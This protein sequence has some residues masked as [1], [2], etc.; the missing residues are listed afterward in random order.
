MCAPNSRFDA[1]WFF[2]RMAKCG[3]LAHEFSRH[4]WEVT[5]DSF[6]IHARA[7]TGAAEAAAYL[8]K[9]ISKGFQRE[10]REDLTGMA[11]RWSSS[12]G[13]PGN[14]DL[15]LR[16][17]DE[18]GWDE[19]IFAPGKVGAHMLG[20]PDDLME[21]VGEDIVMNVAVKGKDNKNIAQLRRFLNDTNVR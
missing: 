18:G 17:T 2:A 6:I 7:V 21:R 16:Q 13:W 1:K 3:C 19:R 4:W 14:I 9:Y 8:G 12:A 11:R 5:G 20:G 10:D 15:H